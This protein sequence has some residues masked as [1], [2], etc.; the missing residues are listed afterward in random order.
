[1]AARPGRRSPRTT[2]A[3]V[4]R[5]ERLTPHMLRL[6]LG[7]PGLA[8]FSVGEF[9]DHYIKL[10]FPPEGVTYSSPFDLARIRE[11]LPR[12]Q[13]PLMRTYTVR[14]WDAERRELA[15]D[16]VIHGDQGVAGR[17]AAR[18]RPGDEVHFAGPGGGYA[19][20]PS[21]DWHLLVGDESA[22]PAI[23][24]ALERMPAGARA[25]VLVEVAG[26]EEEQKLETAADASVTWV[27]RGG[28]RVGEHLVA[29]ARDLDLPPGQVHAF[30]HGEA[31]FVKEL[32]RWLRGDLGVPRERLS[33]S[34]YWRLGLNE[35]GWQTA[36]RDWNRQV[37][38]E[39]E[40]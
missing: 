13:W 27:H 38:E 39:Q 23:A 12:E 4:E 10:L 2:H 19:P 14:W 34:G 35:D 37:E 40:A 16:V 7:G 15:V 26:P 9:T 22:L 5:I 24:A 25:R 18:A 1:M 20:D 36:K 21:A 29:A 28:S 3:R 30:V 31:G 32:R 8:E 33:V 11:E 6:V 17:W